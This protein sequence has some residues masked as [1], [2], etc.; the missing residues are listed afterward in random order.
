MCAWE[1]IR[2]AWPSLLPQVSGAVHQSWAVFRSSSS[3]S[4]LPR[5]KIKQRG[6]TLQSASS[7]ANTRLPGRAVG[8]Q[9]HRSNEKFLQSLTRKA[10]SRILRRFPMFVLSHLHFTLNYKTSRQF[11]LNYSFRPECLI[12]KKERMSYKLT[13]MEIIEYYIYMYTI[14]EMIIY[15]S[16]CIFCAHISPFVRYKTNLVTAKWDH[17]CVTQICL[18][19]KYIHFS[20]I[21]N[22]AE[23]GKGAMLIWC[24]SYTNVCVRN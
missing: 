8:P 9:L 14:F 7:A 21:C 16:R 5:L 17:I 22:Y 23:L 15:C 18:A 11:K 24:F 19:H 12:N 10:A 13:W 3:N 6:N 4:S 1:I 20:W 2:R